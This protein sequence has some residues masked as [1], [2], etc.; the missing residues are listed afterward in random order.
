[1]KKMYEFWLNYEFF[2][3]LFSAHNFYK[4]FIT[5]LYINIFICI[6]LHK[7]YSAQLLLKYIKCSR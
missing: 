1:M 2:F 4:I 7:S 6:Q 5:Y 3:I